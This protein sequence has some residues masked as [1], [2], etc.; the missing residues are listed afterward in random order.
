MGFSSRTY[1]VARDNRVC[2]LASA[3]FGRMLRDPESNRLPAF[4]GQRVRM[5][6][7]IVELV[8]GAPVRVVRNTFAILAFDKEGRLDVERFGRQQ[9]A[10]AESAL[11]P[12]LG[13]CETNGP[14]IDA[15]ARFVAQGGGWTPPEAL[16]R[17]IN[18]AAMGRVPCHHL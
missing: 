14:V 9:F 10:L 18:D 11:A 16:A 5:A 3:K 12:A 7:V 6:S 13:G 15:A 2:R 4:A 17:A 1:L 8:G